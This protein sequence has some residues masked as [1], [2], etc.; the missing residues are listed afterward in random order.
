MKELEAVEVPPEQSNDIDNQG[1]SRDTA[2][3]ASRASD[4]KRSKLHMEVLEAYR[5]VDPNTLE[6]CRVIMTI[7]LNDHFR[8]REV[9]CGMS[10]GLKI[11][12]D[13]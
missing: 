5:K 6:G 1:D 2:K 7:H 13:R 12:Y 8:N 11:L 3:K 10:S 9:G 4:I